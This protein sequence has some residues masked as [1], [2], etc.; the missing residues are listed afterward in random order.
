MAFLLPLYKMLKVCSIVI[1]VQDFDK[2]AETLTNERNIMKAKTQDPRIA[3]KVLEMVAAH[4]KT[5]PDV[6]KSDEGDPI[7]KKVVMYTI[8]EGLGGSIRSAKEAVNKKHDPDV[9]QAVKK[10]KGL[11]KTDTGLASLI[12]EIKTETLMIAAM[13]SGSASAPSGPTS[14][15][16][17]PA[18]RTPRSATAPEKPEATQVIPTGNTAQ[19]IASVQKAVTGVFL[20]ADLLQSRDPASEVMLAKD[21]VVFLVWDDFPKIPLPEILSAFHLDKDGLYRAIGRISVCMKE[22]GSE[23][24]KK[25]KA[26]RGAYSPA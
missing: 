4:Y 14:P 18:A 11:V 15:P 8:K 17:Q 2:H 10:I 6:L 19:T 12:E 9:Y 1:R 13:P 22:D 25:L 7:A 3:Q 5:T 24:K 21:A 26:A 16:R 20:G 23:L